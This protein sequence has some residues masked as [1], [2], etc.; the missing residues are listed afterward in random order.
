MAGDENA[1]AERPVEGQAGV[2]DRQV[3]LGRRVEVG[4]RRVVVC[5]HA[6][7][8]RSQ[9]LLQ[10]DQPASPQEP[11]SGGPLSHVSDSLQ[12]LNPPHDF[13]VASE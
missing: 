7:L 1:S 3:R 13:V 10:V 5:G 12:T 11:L 6:G 4:Q 9:K 8:D 2:G